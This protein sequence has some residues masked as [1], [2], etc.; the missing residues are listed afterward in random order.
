MFIVQITY[1]VP[2]ET[3]DKHLPAHVEWLHEH[4]AAGHFVVYGRLVPRSGG[5]IVA[6]LPSREALDE[7]LYEDPFMKHAVGTYQVLQFSENKGYRAKH[8]PSI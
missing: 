7:I 1:T 6:D 8:G 2:L 5:V 3:V 4:E